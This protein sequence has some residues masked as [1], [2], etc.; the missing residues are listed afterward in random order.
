[1]GAFIACSDFIVSYFKYKAIEQTVTIN[2]SFELVL[3][4]AMND[5]SEAQSRTF[6]LLHTGK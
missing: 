3:I 2:I 4:Q 5:G 6:L 1:L